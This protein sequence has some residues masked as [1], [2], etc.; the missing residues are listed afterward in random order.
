MA[1]SMRDDLTPARIRAARLVAVAADLLQVVL[2]P[3]FFPAA[4]PP[5]NTVIDVIVAVVLLA[6]VGWHWAFLPTFV[7]EAIPFVDL[8]PTWTAAVFLAT[9]GPA[10]PAAPSEVVVEGA[11]GSRP[12]LPGAPPS[13]PGRP[14]AQA[15]RDASGS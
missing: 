11:A 7:A 1:V 12:A 3:T 5:A 13:A 6:L 2:L 8:V 14:A 15:P 10:V 9:R 4:V